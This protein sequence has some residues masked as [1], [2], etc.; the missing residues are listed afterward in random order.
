MPDGIEAQT[1]QTMDNIGAILKRAGLGYDDIFKCTAMLDDMKDWPAFNKVYVAYFPDGN[2]RREARS[3][4]T[5]W[6]SVRC[7]EVECQA[8]AGEEI[9]PAQALL[10][11]CSTS[12]AAY[13][14]RA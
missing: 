13:K 5:A 8:Y 4:P 6:R 11:R 7:I 9:S 12:S 3:A 1:R 10:R 2:C 14:R